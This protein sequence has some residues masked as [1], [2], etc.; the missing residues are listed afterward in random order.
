MSL[1]LAVNIACFVLGHLSL[2]I[3]ISLLGQLT[4]GLVAL[5]PT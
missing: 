1:L 3:N 5:P 4:G 2:G